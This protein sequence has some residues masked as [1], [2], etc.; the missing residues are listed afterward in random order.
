MY[1]DLYNFFLSAANTNNISSSGGHGDQQISA[2]KESTPAPEGG[3][4]PQRDGKPRSQRPPQ[5]RRPND[6][7]KETLVNGTTA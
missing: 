2:N 7:P 4:K 3:P 6:K 1:W 5:S